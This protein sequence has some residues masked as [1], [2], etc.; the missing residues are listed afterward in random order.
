[1]KEIFY[2]HPTRYGYNEIGVQFCCME[3]ASLLHCHA[4]Y[5]RAFSTEAVSSV[6][7][8]AACPVCMCVCCISRV[9]PF[10]DSTP[11]SPVSSF[12]F[13]AKF[14]LFWKCALRYSGYLNCV[15]FWIMGSII[16][17]GVTKKPII[18]N[19]VTSNMERWSP[20]FLLS[21]LLVAS[22][23]SEDSGFAWWT[24]SQG[25]ER[26]ARVIGPMLC[27]PLLC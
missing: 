4:S 23:T 8:A 11:W 21:G 27:G 16:D 6:P 1:M 17:E 3:S 12:S 2:K 13:S 14:S 10:V 15:H 22:E 19:S 18:K 9:F 5:P 7:V 20:S 24:P 26:A 25:P